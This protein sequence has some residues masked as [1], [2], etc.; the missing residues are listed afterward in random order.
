[1][2]S[3]TITSGHTPA[4]FQPIIH[5]LEQRGYPSICPHLPTCDASAIS[6]NPQI[7]M[8]SDADFIESVLRHLVIDEGK[9]VIVV[10]HSY[11]GVP[12]SQAIPEELGLKQRATAGK[13][14]G[15]IGILYTTAFLLAPNTSIKDFGGGQSPPWMEYRVSRH[16]SLP[17]TTRRFGT[18]S[19]TGTVGESF[20]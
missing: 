2:I 11:G 14:G 1:M 10:P 19:A 8:Y 15:V 6:K 7:D 16:S 3:L 9:R 18:T 17:Q 12:A 4:F 5:H 13:S 20:D